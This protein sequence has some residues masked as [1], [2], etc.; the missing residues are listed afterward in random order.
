MALRTVKLLLAAIFSLFTITFS[1]PL[2][3]QDSA[4][5]NLPKEAEAA[6]HAEQKEGFN[7]AEVIFGHI[8]DNHEYIM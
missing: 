2:L 6:A 3:A 7:A 5:A 8:L 1:A 4:H